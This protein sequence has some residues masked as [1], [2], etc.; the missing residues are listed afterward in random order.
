MIDEEG[1]SYTTLYAFNEGAGWIILERIIVNEE[2]FGTFTEK[3]YFI[4][5]IKNELLKYENPRLDHIYLSG[6][7]G[8]YMHEIYLE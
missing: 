2:D 4:I 5:R 3:G 6:K 8:T 1:K 7:D